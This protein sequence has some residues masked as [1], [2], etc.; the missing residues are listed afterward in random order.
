MGAGR[1]GA[2]LLYR[3]EVVSIKSFGNVERAL[4]REKEA[5]AGGSCGIRGVKGVDSHRDDSFNGGKV[6]NSKQVAWELVWQLGERM[7]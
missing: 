3:G 4:S 7:G 1:T 5:M 6:S 2:G